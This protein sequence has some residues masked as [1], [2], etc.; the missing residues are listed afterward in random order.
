METAVC[1]EP[2]TSQKG[3]SSF[4]RGRLVIWSHWE[5]PIP[6][7]QVKWASE[8]RKATFLARLGT[9]ASVDRTV[10]MASGFVR[11]RTRKVAERVRGAS[12][13]WLTEFKVLIARLDDLMEGS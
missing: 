3:C 2:L 13:G 12:T 10:W 4:G 11:D 8:S 9:L 7:V 5:L 1:L 6:T